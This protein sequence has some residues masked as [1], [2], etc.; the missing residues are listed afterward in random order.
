MGTVNQ[1]RDV[2]L[3]VEADKEWPQQSTVS[4]TGPQVRA[5]THRQLCCET[6]RGAKRSPRWGQTGML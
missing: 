1:K 4:P 2:D 5:R 3:Q 6:V